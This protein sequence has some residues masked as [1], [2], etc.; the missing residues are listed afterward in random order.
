[1]YHCSSGGMFDSEFLHSCVTKKWTSGNQTTVSIE[2]T[3]RDR[4]D[5][6]LAETVHRPCIVEQQN[7]AGILSTGHKRKSSSNFDSSHQE[8]AIFR[9]PPCIT[10]RSQQMKDLRS[11]NIERQNA[12]ES[13]L[14]GHKR[15][16]ASNFNGS[17]PEDAVFRRPLDVTV[18]SRQTGPRP[19]NVE[20]QNTT[21]SSSAEHNRK[22]HPAQNRSANTNTSFDGSRHERPLDIT[23]GSKPTGQCSRRLSF[24]SPSS[25][26]PA[27]L[28]EHDHTQDRT[29]PA[30][31]RSVQGP[32]PL[33][34]LS[35]I[36]QPVP[37]KEK[38]AQW[39]TSSVLDQ[40]NPPPSNDQ[41]TV[42]H[43]RPS[44]LDHFE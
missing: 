1:M 37:V 31:R 26:P 44:I 42:L 16:S 23:V 8:D 4:P 20:R 10:E 3:P 6:Q 22:A 11:S 38:V 41:G 29:R 30:T 32:A 12:T 21:G 35:S 33:S 19:S 7:S 14:T 5:P 24:N 27:S 15:K 18:R 39:L 36:G 43:L 40:E 13:S 34:P 17:H 28:E 9:R 25:L 2:A